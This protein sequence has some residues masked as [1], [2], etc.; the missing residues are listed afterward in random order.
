MLREVVFLASVDR[1]VKESPGLKRKEGR[2]K[3][4]KRKKE[5][6]PKLHTMKRRKY[7]TIQRTAIAYV[8]F[9][10][11]SPD[12]SV[13]NFLKRAS[14]LKFLPAYFWKSLNLT[15]A[16]DKQSSLSANTDPLIQKLSPLQTKADRQ[17]SYDPLCTILYAPA[18]ACCGY[19]P[20]PVA[21]NCL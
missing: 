14:K 19:L 3:R 13:K 16:D 11:S 7:I 9:K 4:R 21:S 10:I 2:R 1:H 6:S 17:A 18:P 20:W 15:R 5:L 12:F 8:C